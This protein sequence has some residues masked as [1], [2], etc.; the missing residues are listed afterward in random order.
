MMTISV[1]K[2]RAFLKILNTPLSDL[3]WKTKICQLEDLRVGAFSIRPCHTLNYLHFTP[4]F[5]EA[6]LWHKTLTL[7]AKQFMKSTSG[8]NPETC[9]N[10]SCFLFF[11]RWSIQPATWWSI[12][13]WAP[14]FEQSVSK[15][16][17]LWQTSSNSQKD[18]RETDILSRHLINEHLA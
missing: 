14:N 8:S 11:F 15:L 7:G 12:V 10:Q 18:F 17:Q 2:F 5:W 9:L 3:S 4:N 16:P 13:S 1:L 6:F